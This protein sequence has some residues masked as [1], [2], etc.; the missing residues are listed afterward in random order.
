[1]DFGC[2]KQLLYGIVNVPLKTVVLLFILL[3][4]KKFISFILKTK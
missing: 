4:P 3:L 1:M 2:D